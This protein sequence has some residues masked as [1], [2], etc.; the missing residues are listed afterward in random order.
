MFGHFACSFFLTFNFFLILTESK[1]E[2][3]KKLMLKTK[4]LKQNLTKRLKNASGRNE[5]R[6]RKFTA[7]F[8]QNTRENDHFPEQDHIGR[9]DN[10]L[11][12]RPKDREFESYSSKYFFS[13][14][15]GVGFF[16]SCMCL[17]MFVHLIILF[18]KDLKNSVKLGRKRNYN[19]KKFF[20]TKS[21]KQNSHKRKI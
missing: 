10:A 5:F 17:K 6:R 3:V 20:K 12:L 7:I 14:G 9:V 2:C 4:C 18:S 21:R 15:W 19:A 11:D 8:S 13:W 1:L 16:S